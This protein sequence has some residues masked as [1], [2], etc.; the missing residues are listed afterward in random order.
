[1]RVAKTPVLILA[2]YQL[3]PDVVDMPNSKFGNHVYLVVDSA[4]AIRTK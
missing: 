4:A 2:E 3:L 1:M